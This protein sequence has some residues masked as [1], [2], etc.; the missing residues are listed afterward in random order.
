MTYVGRHG[1]VENNRV[2]VHVAWS[3]MDFPVIYAQQGT[4]V[5]G[6]WRAAQV[7]CLCDGLLIGS[8]VFLAR[9]SMFQAAVLCRLAVSSEYHGLSLVACLSPVLLSYTKETT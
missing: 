6:S 2:H 8:L 7:M 9:F 4:S 3:D 5:R 1:L